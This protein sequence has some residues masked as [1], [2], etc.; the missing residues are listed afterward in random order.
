MAPLIALTL[1]TL[2]ARGYGA[3]R[4]GPLRTWRG[5]L[6]PGLAL[7]F[8]VTGIS[9]FVGLRADLVAI[10]PPALPRPDLLV[11]LTGLLELGGAAAL[12]ARRTAGPAALGLTGLLVGIFPANVYAATHDVPMGARSPLPCWP[13]PCCSWSTWPR[14]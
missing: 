4:G 5:A 14:R 9:H 3:L 11:T 10:V 12:L 6:A 7:M 13:G 8:T 1:G 2:L